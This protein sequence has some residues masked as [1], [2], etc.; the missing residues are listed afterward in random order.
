MFIG[1]VELASPLAEPLAATWGLAL[2]LVLSRYAT[3]RI[4]TCPGSMMANAV[5]PEC[6]VIRPIIIWNVPEAFGSTFFSSTQWHE[7]LG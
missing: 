1:E 2:T 4:S 6:I 5:L 3:S 7:A